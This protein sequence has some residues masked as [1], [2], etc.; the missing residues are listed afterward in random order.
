MLRLLG[1]YKQGNEIKG[2]KCIDD[3]TLNIGVFM[4]PFSLPSFI[5]RDFIIK[6]NEVKPINGCID[7]VMVFDLNDSNKVIEND[8]LLFIGNSVDRGKI[9]LMV[10]NSLGAYT[11]YTASQLLSIIKK[12]KIKVYNLNIEATKRGKTGVYK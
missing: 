4:F 2:I 7:D 5:K 10:V 11:G 8:G 3:E 1:V 6:Y 12:N 9:V